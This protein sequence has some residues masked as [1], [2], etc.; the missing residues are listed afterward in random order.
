MTVHLR[1]TATERLSPLVSCVYIYIFFSLGVL[2]ASPSQN[3]APSAKFTSSTG[4]QEGGC[5][6][7]TGPGCMSGSLQALSATA[8]RE[9]ARKALP[10]MEREEWCS[11]YAATVKRQQQRQLQQQWNKIRNSGIDKAFQNSLF[12]TSFLKTFIFKRLPVLHAHC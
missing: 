8:N 7:K 2:F 12:S 4:L 9:G 5:S 6:Q 11:K 1:F 3:A 10:S